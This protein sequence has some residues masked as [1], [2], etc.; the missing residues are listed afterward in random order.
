MKL[1]KT[2]L[3]LM[4]LVVAAGFILYQVPAVQ[5]RLFRQVAQG[6]DLLIHDALSKVALLAGLR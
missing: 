2:G 3:L 5:A 1:L 6:T 4:A